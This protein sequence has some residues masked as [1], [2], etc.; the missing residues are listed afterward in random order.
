MKTSYSKRDYDF[1][2]RMFKLRSTISLSQE[3]LGKHIGI[4]GRAVSEWETGTSYPKT[5]RL[6]AFIA[7]AIQHQA[8]PPGHEAEEIRVLWKAAHQKVPLDEDWLHALLAGQPS[9]QRSHVAEENGQGPAAVPTRRNGQG[10]AAIPTRR[11]GQGPAAIPTRRDEQGPAVAPTWGSGQE[12]V[13]V[14]TMMQNLPFP[15]NPFFTGRQHLLKH[16]VHLF[17]SNERIAITQPVSISG[18]GGIGKTQLALEYAHRCYP[19]IY[20]CVLWVNAADKA[21]LETSYLALARLLELVPKQEREVERIVRAVNVWLEQHGSWLLILDNADDLEL[22]SR[23]LPTHPRGHILLT[24][25][26]QIVG[27]VAALLPVDAMS[28]E[29]GLLFLLRRSGVL[30]SS[31]AIERIPA[32]MRHEAE[33]L[34]ETPGRS[35]SGYRSSGSLH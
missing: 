1:G 15:P 26:T 10:P 35:S 25:R 18:L 17:E 4:S 22:A 27:H 11:N 20:R 21:A 7:L 16:L 14:P 34:V 8:F 30:K 32:D 9:P 23:F 12:Q 31:T 19:H 2:H 13:A 28:R 29:E 24:T 33:R 6:K 5:E 3:Q